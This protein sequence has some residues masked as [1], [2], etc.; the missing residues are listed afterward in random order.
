VHNGPIT[1]LVFSVSH[2]VYICRK[3]TLVGTNSWSGFR[4]ATGVDA[5]FSPDPSRPRLTPDFADSQ[6]AGGDTRR[7]WAWRSQPPA[8]AFSRGTPPAVSS[9]RVA[10]DPDASG[11]TRWL[12]PPCA[13]REAVASLMALRLGGRWRWVS[14][15]GRGR[16][17]AGGRSLPRLAEVP[18]ARR[19]PSVSCIRIRLLL[20]DVSAAATARG[21]PPALV[22]FPLALPKQISIVSPHRENLLLRHNVAAVDCI[23]RS[24]SMLLNCANCQFSLCC[25]LC[26]TRIWLLT[27]ARCT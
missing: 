10:G 9:R 14:R 16:C 15:L 3:F 6:T 18:P 13:W 11:E 2:D 17:V 23:S 24:F 25:S 8:G 1:L 5:I 20:R 22:S 12:A 27:V 19:V 7:L 21:P 4:L 26:P